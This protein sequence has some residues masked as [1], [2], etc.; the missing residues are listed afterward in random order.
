MHICF[1]SHNENKVKEMNAIMPKGISIIGL[2]E[3]GITEEI[4]ETGKTLEENSRIKASHVYERKGMPVFAD[5]SGLLVKA[6]KGEPGVYS[7]R[8]AGPERDDNKNMDLLLGRLTDHIDRSAE[9]QTVITFINQHGDTKQFKGVV[10]G[11]ITTNKKGRNGFGYDPIFQPL[12]Q[13]QTFA[14]MSNEIKNRISHRA[15]AV[16][17]L[18]EYLHQHHG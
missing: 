15:K 18:L 6:L 2:K 11:T 1:A 17:K 4:A 8:Y 7:A 9:F 5:D 12:N 14:E 13:T 3:L 10:E 16:Q